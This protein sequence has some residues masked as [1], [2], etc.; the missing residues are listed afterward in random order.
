MVLER[1]GYGGCG[2]LIDD[3]Q[4]T[5]ACVSLWCHSGVIVVVH[6]CYQINKT[7]RVFFFKIFLFFFFFRTGVLQLC[8]MRCYMGD[9]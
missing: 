3:A 2:G 4:D 6:G 5:Q 1:N 9:T 8:H 7:K